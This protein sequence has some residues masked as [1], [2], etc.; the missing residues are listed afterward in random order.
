M[1]RWGYFLRDKFTLKAKFSIQ[2]CLSISL[3]PDNQMSYFTQTYAP[4]LMVF[5]KSGSMEPSNHRVEN[6]AR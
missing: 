3:L 1:T 4:L 2:T 6:P 5:L